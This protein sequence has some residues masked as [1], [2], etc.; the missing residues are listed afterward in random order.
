[1]EIVERK[2]IPVQFGK[3]GRKG[4]GKKKKKCEKR[5]EGVNRRGIPN[6]SSV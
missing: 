3:E 6:L 4:G 1:M 2:K 5:K